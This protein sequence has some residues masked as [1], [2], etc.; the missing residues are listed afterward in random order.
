MLLIKDASE[1]FLPDGIQKNASILIENGRIKKIGKNFVEKS[2]DIAEIIDAR[3][4]TIL[5]GFVDCHT[6]AIFAD[7]RE[8][9]LEMKLN[10][11]TYEEIAA[12][13][14]GIN[15]TV[16]KTRHASFHQL[17]SESKQRLDRM[18]EYGTTTAEVKSGYGLDVES[19][20]KILRV[21]RELDEKHDI[22]IVPTFLGAHAIPPEMEK[23]E[24]IDVLIDEMIPIIADEKLA[25]FCDVFCERGYFTADES[26]KILEAGKEY[27][28]E[29]KIHADEFSSC[30]GAELAAEINAISADHLLMASD[31]GM[32]EMAKANVIAV[33]LPA[34]PFSLMLEK[35]AN[36]RKMIGMG[37]RVALATDLNPNCW[38]ENMQFIIQLACFKMGMTPREAIEGATINAARAIGMEN[39]VGS[40]EE[41]KKA[42]LLIVDAPSHVFLPYHF[43]VNLVETVIKNG[44][45]V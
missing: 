38:T 17:L 14:G 39:E 28:M 33:L 34:A 10:G 42:D 9:E 32:K 5:P 45:V 36:A 7:S 8:F 16:E 24:Y 20:I 19:E 35:Y 21:A 31:K 3:G 23:E 44:N 2:A 43:G 25:R 29:A 30:G 27:G 37:I 26:R 11:A 41:G 4:K 12:S 13:G 15:Y 40:I 6:H 18:L 1:V 22:G